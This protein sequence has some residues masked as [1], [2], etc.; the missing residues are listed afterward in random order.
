MIEEPSTGDDD[1]PNK[2]STELQK[3][4]SVSSKVGMDSI[5]TYVINV[6]MRLFPS[7]TNQETNLSLPLRQVSSS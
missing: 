2:F 5:Q 3:C 6:L 4:R 1:L 7:Q